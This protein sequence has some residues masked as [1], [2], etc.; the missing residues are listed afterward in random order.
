[1]RV[2]GDTPTEITTTGT[3]IFQTTST[4]GVHKDA[5]TLLIHTCTDVKIESISVKKH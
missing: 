3:T 1:M 2:F 4:A 5:V